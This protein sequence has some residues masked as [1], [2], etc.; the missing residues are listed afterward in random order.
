M[1]EE[2]HKS[3]TVE[4]EN[5][6]SK[7]LFGNIS[8]LSSRWQS[9]LLRVQSG[10]ILMSSF[11]LV[12]RMGPI[13][14]LLLTYLVQIVS[15]HEAMETA[16]LFTKSEDLRV[17][18]W[19][20][21]LLAN[22]FWTNPIVAKYSPASLDRFKEPMCFLTYLLLIVWFLLSMK[23]A[24]KCLIKYCH[25]AWTHLLIL[26]T[27]FQASLVLHTL[28][29]GMVWY[30]F[31]MSI[32]TINDI[33]AYMCGFF[34]GSRS[35]I[36]VSPKK[37]VEGYVGGGLLT[38]MLGP[39]YGF[40]LLQFPSIL[41]PTGGLSVLECDPLSYPLYSGSIPPFILHCLV[42]SIFAS[43]FG[44]TAGFL[45]SGFKRACNKKNFGNFIPGHGG[46]LDRCDCMF[47]MASFTYVY[48]K[49]FVVAE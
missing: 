1:P 21:L 38:I 39:S 30:I 36:V 15:F 27:A 43:T 20:L 18:S 46:V 28:Q 12:V 3:K 37:T 49:H 22:I 14:L 44:P 17:W 34:F 41:C 31:A 45:C 42:I 47:L 10:F 32:I 29:H 33:S 9:W 40:L 5:L 7:F 11:Y 6:N 8:R 2:E 4:N 13:G 48:V 25:F 23:D 16:I 35:L 19:Q 26:F 24:S